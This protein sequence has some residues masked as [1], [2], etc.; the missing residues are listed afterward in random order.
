MTRTLISLD[1][2]LLERTRQRAADLGISLAEHVR[3]L[4]AA[5]LGESRAPV[6]PSVVFDLGRSGG[7]DVARDEDAMIGAAVA[8]GS[9]RGR[10]S[11]RGR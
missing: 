8:A 9:R 11:R 7:S 5:D 10:S 1:R 3:R 4:L 6:D 2:D